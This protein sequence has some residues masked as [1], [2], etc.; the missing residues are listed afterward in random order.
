MRLR[1][2]HGLVWRNLRARRLRSSLTVCGIALGIALM[3]GTGLLTTTIDATFHG[4]FDAIYGKIDLAISTP[5]ESGSIKASTLRKVRAAKDVQ[6]AYGTLYA[7]VVR[8]KHKTLTIPA[9]RLPPQAAALGRP[10]R[11]R[12]MRPSG[13]PLNLAGQSTASPPPYSSKLVRGRRPRHGHELSVESRWLQGQHLGVGDHVALG[14]PDGVERFE[15][16]GSYR[17]RNGG[18]PG[19]SFG[20]I[21]LAVARKG[22][23]HRHG[24]D[25]I[26]VVLKPSA[27]THTAQA[28]LQR[29]VGDGLSVDTPRGRAESVL[30][31]LA[32]LRIV[33][34]IMSG[35]GAFVGVFLVFNAFSM[36]VLE[37]QRELGILRAIG[38]RS[39]TLTLSVLLESL[40]LGVVGTAAGLAL[41]W[42]IAS[43]LVTLAGKV[44]FPLTH[45]RVATA[46]LVASLIAGVLV[47]MVG[48]LRPAWRAGRSSPLT[49][50]AARGAGRRRP[51]AWR[52]LAG[53]TLIGAGAA[54]TWALTRGS[55]AGSWA[56]VEGG[57]SVALLFLGVALVSPFLIAPTVKQLVWPMRWV[58]P[59]ESHLAANATTANPA[60]SATTA[61]TLVVGLGLVTAFG[62]IG[63]SFLATVSDEVNQSIGGDLTVQPRSLDVTSQAPQQTFARS[64]RRRI[65][66]LPQAAVVTPQRFF[67]TRHLVKKKTGVAF[68]VDPREYGKVSDT[69]YEGGV[70]EDR[71][72]DR[73]AHGDVAVSDSLARRQ[74]L[75]AGDTIRLHGTRETRRARI[76][77]ISRSVSFGGRQVQMSLQTM[78][79]LY[80]VK[81]DSRLVVAAR[82]KVDRK[83]LQG[84][85]ENILDEHY[86]QLRALTNSAL[87]DDI[88]TRLRRELGLF[89]ILLFI[90]VCTSL[91]GLASTMAMSVL[92]RT[93]EIGVLRALGCSRLR[94]RNAIGTEATVLA[95]I[96]A[97]L[98][99]ILGLGLGYLLVQAL[100]NVLPSIHYSLPIQA[101]GAVNGTAFAMGV[102]ASVAPARRAA[103]MS[104][105]AALAYE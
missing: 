105:T 57:L 78:S 47:S 52:A 4:L 15:I 12:V 93:R 3:F 49:A 99:N 81:R 14:L 28:R 40:V 98:G 35:L 27:D 62:S 46:P 80:G 51:P 79:A 17:F 37:R 42:G 89:D 72:L 23:D 75:H 91:F 86:P 55:I 29:L 94:L 70:S 92:E 41:G 19:Q 60:R 68:G 26:D 53:A 61:T 43:G 65:A 10:V 36:T 48:A 77:A 21:P 8:L 101:I 58:M 30:D 56:I 2:F 67:F 33:L 45:L 76:A 64:V 88:H 7:P 66:K 59:V 102:L 20:T 44:N 38:A 90:A 39:G 18:V 71:V 16:V 9:S 31:E 32:A 1:S 13:E 100:Q 25:E 97:T 6:A 50:M 83:P 24:F 54:G 95:M 69:R 22:F 5:T 104:V 63:S 87:K 34:A 96:G 85:V 74:K 103:K 73:L 11:R 84:A 82:S